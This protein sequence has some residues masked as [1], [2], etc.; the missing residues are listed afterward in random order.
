MWTSLFVDHFLYDEL[1]DWC[2]SYTQLRRTGT[3]KRR[4]IETREFQ[5][6]LSCFLARFG[7]VFF[8]EMGVCALPLFKLGSLRNW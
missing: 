6:A 4:A 8:A 7:C 1:C 3:V 5:H 2:V